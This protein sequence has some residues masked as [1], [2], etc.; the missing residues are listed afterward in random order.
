MTKP[1]PKAGMQAQDNN[2]KVYEVA[3]SGALLRRSPKMSGKDRRLARSMAKMLDLKPRSLGATAITY[4]E[5]CRQ[6]DKAIQLGGPKPDLLVL[7]GQ[8]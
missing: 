4:D 1:H 8:S 2:G 5:M 3:P 6:Y 7:E